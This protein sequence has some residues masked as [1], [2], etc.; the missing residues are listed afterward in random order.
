MQENCEKNT[1]II[2]R[3]SLYVDNQDITFN[4]IANKINVSNSYFSKMVKNSGSLGEDVIT[5]ILLYYDNINPAWL[6]TGE[7]EMLRSGKEVKPAELTKHHHPSYKEKEPSNS[8]IPLYDIDAAANLHN[9]A[10]QRDQNVINNLS[11]PGIPECDGAIYVRGDSMYP[12]IKSGDI[13]VFKI[14]KDFNLL[15]FGEMYLIDFSLEGVDYLVLKYVRKSNIT[16]HIQLISHNPLHDPMDIPIAGCI[17]AMAIVK[18]S[19][20]FNT[21]I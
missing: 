1:K 14:I 10:I 13:V 11:I 5:K 15:I 16:D 6:L 7:G 19:I 4:Q 2:D 20:R 17:R 21:M 18:A 9:I 12:L 8:I 3:L